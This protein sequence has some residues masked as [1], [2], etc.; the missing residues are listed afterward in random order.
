MLVLTLRNVIVFG[1]VRGRIESLVL[2]ISGGP[3]LSFA[4]LV[5]FLVRVICLMTTGV[6][7]F[8]LL[9]I[10]C[11]L[12]DSALFLF[13]ERLLSLMPWPSLVCGTLDLFCALL[14]GSSQRSML[15]VFPLFGLERRTRSLV[16]FF[17]SPSLLVGLV[18]LMSWLNFVLFMWPRFI[19]FVSSWTLFFKLFCLQFFA[20]DPSVVLADPA[21]YPYDLLPAF[22]SSVFRVWGLLGGHGVFPNLSF[23]KSGI[24]TSVQCSSVK[25]A[26][27]CL[28]PTVVPHCVAKF[29]PLFGDLYWPMTWSQVQIMPFD[30]HV[31]DFSWLLAHGVVLTADRLRS[32]FYMSSVPPDCFCGAPL[33]ATG[34]LF[35]QCPLAQSVLAWIQSLLVIAVPSAPSLSPSC[36]VW[37]RYC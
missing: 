26:Y 10:S 9:K 13:R 17:V 27:W 24:V 22:Y 29:Q 1:W 31:A 19:V 3:L 32:S 2:L 30:R 28:R 14:T 11:S 33:E 25:L 23:V 37:F 16:M 34:H 8:R 20:D 6:P 7:G 15:R 5:L 18:L 4:A 12:G 21:Y 36:F 35:F